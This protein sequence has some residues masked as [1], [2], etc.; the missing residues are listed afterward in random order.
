MWWKKTW[1]GVVGRILC[2]R[3]VYKSLPKLSS[4]EHAGEANLWPMLGVC[5]AHT[6]N[7]FDADLLMR[8][9][10]PP[11]NACKPL[12]MAELW[13]LPVVMRA[14]LLEH[15]RRV[16]VRVVKAQASR[17]AA[18]DFANDLIAIAQKTPE[19]EQPAI[20]LPPGRLRQPFVVQLVQRL[21]YQQPGL[22][23]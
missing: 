3:R 6:D 4:G 18:D 13:T 20:V 16:A 1:V 11:I 21:R 5:R 15:L 17:Q 12:T 10:V 7:H 19:N 8:F 23:T 2:S 9:V 14:V 22:C